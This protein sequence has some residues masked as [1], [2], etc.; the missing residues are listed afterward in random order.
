VAE[1]SQTLGRIYSALAAGSKASGNVRLAQ[2]NDARQW[3]QRSLDIWQELGARNALSAS[4]TEN[5]TTIQNEL[6]K[7]N[8]ELARL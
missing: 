1:S 5:I 3:Y 7:C 4:Q 6:D 8:A 2:L